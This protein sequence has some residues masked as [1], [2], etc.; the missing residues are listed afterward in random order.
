MKKKKAKSKKKPAKPKAK[1]KPLKKK[2]A[3][4][5]K[6][7]PKKPVK[8]SKKVM[9]P[10]SGSESSS[11]D[12]KRANMFGLD[13]E[14]GKSHRGAQSG[15][16]QGIST[17]ALDDSESAEELMEEG[18]DLEGELVK[19]IEDALDA[20]QGEIHTHADAEPDDETPDYSKRNR[21]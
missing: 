5:A 14:A 12:P 18:Q 2:L 6:P 19:G 8:K 17:A 15:D 16:F 11:L 10:S 13:P 21:L 3:K 7:A 4:R 9:E 1:K 20:D